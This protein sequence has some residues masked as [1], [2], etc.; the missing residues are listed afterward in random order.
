MKAEKILLALFLSLHVC[1]ARY[2]SGNGPSEV[3]VCENEHLYIRCYDEDEFI[4]IISVNYGRIGNNTI[5]P[6]ADHLVNDINCQSSTSKAKVTL[7][8]DEKRECSLK[9]ENSVFGDPCVG[10][11]KY[12]SVVHTCIELT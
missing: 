7:L 8:C 11:Y 5:C 6:A 4:K 1:V 3:N 9:A 2:I 10:T 12:L